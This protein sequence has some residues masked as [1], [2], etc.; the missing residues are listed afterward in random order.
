MRR[1][2]KCLKHLTFLAMIIFL[3]TF[4]KKNGQFLDK[5]E[6]KHEITANFRHK[7][8]KSGSN[9]GKTDEKNSTDLSLRT[10]NNHKAKQKTIVLFTYYRSGSTFTGQL[11]NQ[12]PG[13]A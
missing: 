3:W 2:L 7:N 9:H 8:G 1:I 5:R 12:H 4:Y 13:I 6:I 11:L 10:T